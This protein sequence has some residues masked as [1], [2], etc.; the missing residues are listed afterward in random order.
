MSLIQGLFILILHVLHNEKVRQTMTN[1]VQGKSTSSSV[2]SFN[3]NQRIANMVRVSESSS[4]QPS[5]ASSSDSPISYKAR[6]RSGEEKKA[7]R[8]TSDRRAAV[9]RKNKAPLGD[10]DERR[11]SSPPLVIRF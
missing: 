8:E 10:H 9:R 1:W 2:G 11:S 4:S 7:N 3:F 5:T 6:L